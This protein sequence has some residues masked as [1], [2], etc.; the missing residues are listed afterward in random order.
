MDLARKLWRQRGKR[1]QRQGTTHHSRT[2]QEESITHLVD[3]C[4]LVISV[5]IIKHIL[6]D[7]IKTLAPCTA[8]RSYAA[9]CYP[10]SEA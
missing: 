7:L 8:S 2:K 6:A 10:P 5:T 1:V 9:R 3:H 4:C